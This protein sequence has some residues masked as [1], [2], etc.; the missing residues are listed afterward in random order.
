MPVISGGALSLVAF[1]DECAARTRT[2]EPLRDSTP[3]L[4]PPGGRTGLPFLRTFNI[5]LSGDRSGFQRAL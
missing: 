5:D 1:E 2:W 4:A 3:N